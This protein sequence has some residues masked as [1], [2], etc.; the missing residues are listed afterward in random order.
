[1]DGAAANPKPI[2]PDTGLKADARRDLG[3]ALNGVLA[4]T[5][6]LMVKT[7]AYHWN[8]VGPLFYTLHKMT[9][10]Q[11]EDMFKAVDEIAERV[12]ALGELTSFSFADMA[13]VSVVGEHRGDTAAQSMIEQLIASH[14]AAV[15]RMREV[16]EK[17]ED[18][19]DAVTADLLTERM[20]KHEETIWMLQSLIAD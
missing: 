3:R 7:Q 13:A 15:Q 19:R 4:D 20:S 9:E 16:T 11:Y 1:M 6:V 2:D 10:E 12:R 8:V 17:A 18:M 14:Q 5:Y